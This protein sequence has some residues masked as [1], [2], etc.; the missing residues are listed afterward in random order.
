VKKIIK[1]TALIIVASF[2]LLTG[3]NCFPMLTMKPAKTGQIE[4]TNIYAVKNGISTVYFIKTGS[5]YIMI[6]AGSNLK[7]L[8]SS[9]KEVNIGID[10]V[11]W[12][13]LTHSDNDHVAGLTLFPNAE[14]YMSEDEFP[15]ING[16]IKRSFLFGKN[17][18]PE[19]IDIDSITLLTD[20]EELSFG[21]T[22]IKCIK[23]PG[24]TNGSMLYLA[25]GKYLFTG[26]AF[27]INNGNIKVHPFTMDTKLAKLTIEQ[28]YETIHMSSI[29]LTS[30]YGAVIYK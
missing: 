18:M 5:G 28:L 12:I 15:M 30:H 9:L 29:I 6:D 25:D 17:T 16:A 8:E 11:K 19:R 2:I 24:H 27:R 7:K 13:L 23:A 20:Y 1:K 10:D 22:E 26:D 4:D 3:I 14:I 21:E